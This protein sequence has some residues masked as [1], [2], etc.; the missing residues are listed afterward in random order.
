MVERRSK[1]IDIVEEFLFISGVPIPVFE[2]Y[3][4]KNSPKIFGYN[5]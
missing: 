1:V 3:N 2:E 4:R 5:F